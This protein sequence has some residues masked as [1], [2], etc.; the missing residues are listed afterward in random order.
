MQIPIIA[1]RTFEERDGAGGAPVVILNERAAQDLFGTPSAAI[2]RRVRL[3][4]EPWREVVGVV[5]GVRS[6]FFNTLEWKRDPIVYRPAAQG[7]GGLSNPTA[8]SFGFQLHIRSNRPLAITAVRTAALS[9]NSRAV[10]TEIRRAPD[11]IA[12]ATRQPAFRTTLLFWFAAVSL[13]LAAIGVYGLVS[14]AV[15]QRLRE[16][17]IRLA[18]GAEPLGL[19]ATVTR[20]ALAAAVAGLVIGAVAALVLGHTLKALLRRATA[21]RRIVC[22]GRGDAAGCYR[23]RRVRPRTPCQPSRSGERPS[24]GLVRLG[25]QQLVENP[26]LNAEP[27]E[28]AQNLWHLQEK[29][30]GRAA[31]G[32]DRKELTSCGEQSLSQGPLR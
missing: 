2:G 11:M 10:V 3:D 20:R 9:I 8:T 26:T 16:L 30:D 6:T 17:A 27:A 7:F 15:T 29:I 14:Q 5:G 23:H 19:A 25:A 18:L 4:K 24:R 28:I 21:R 32:G 31:E 22:G 1:G 13:L 12:E